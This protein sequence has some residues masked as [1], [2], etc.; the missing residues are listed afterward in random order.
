MKTYAA[1]ING[2]KINKSK[3]AKV[4]LKSDSG[5]EHRKELNVF[6]ITCPWIAT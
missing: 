6:F 1:G 5:Q 3:A 2:D 4:G